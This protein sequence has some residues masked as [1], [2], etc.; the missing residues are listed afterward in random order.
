ML[1]KI[2]ANQHLRQTGGI[3]IPISANGHRGIFLVPKS[4]VKPSGIA[5]S[6]SWASKSLIKI[7][8]R[9]TRG[10]Q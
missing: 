7:Y 4:E 2:Q 9:V 1:L 5:A 8:Y 10:L 3:K 6:A